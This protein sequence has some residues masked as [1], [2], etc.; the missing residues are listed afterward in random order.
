MGLAEIEVV[1]ARKAA[2]VVEA[3]LDFGLVTDNEEET[4]DRFEA[5]YGF[6]AETAMRIAEGASRPSKDAPLGISL[7][8]KLLATSIKAAAERDAGIP[9]F[10]LQIIEMTVA[11]PVYPEM[12]VEIEEETV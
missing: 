4:R 9:V 5:K 1:V 7:A 2:D 3:A 6:E 8:A 10:N 11:P 12:I